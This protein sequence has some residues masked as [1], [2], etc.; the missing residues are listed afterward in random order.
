MNK[1]III[2]INGIVFHIEEEAYDVLRSYMID[3]KKYFGHTPDSIEIVGDIEN[4]I[5]EMFSERIQAGKK[6]VITMQDVNEVINQMGSVNEFGSEATQEESYT[7]NYQEPEPSVRRKLMRD[8]ED[9]VFGG[10][11]S[12]IGHYFGIEARWV[13]LIFILLFLTAGTGFLFYIILWAVVPVAKNRADRMAMRGEAPNLK[14]FQRSFQEEMEGIR[15]NFSEAGGSGRSMLRSAGTIITN[16]IVFM[17]KA[18]GILI[19]LAICFG[20]VTLLISVMATFGA[21][22]GLEH[23]MSMFPMNIVDPETRT[24]LLI[25]ALA[26]VAIPLFAFIGLIIRILFNRVF[27]G[28]YT[29]FTLLTIWLF[30]IGVCIHYGINIGADFREE[31]TIVEEKPLEAYP[32]YTLRMND[33]SIIKLSDSTYIDDRLG[34]V[35]KT[36]INRNSSLIEKFRRVSI[37]VDRVDSLQQPMVIYEF[38]AHGKTYDLA[39]ERAARLSYQMVQKEN[40]LVFDSHF[41]LQNDELMREQD[42]D[43]RILLPVGTQ[44][45]IHPDAHRYLSN[46][47]LNQCRKNYKAE[48]GYEPSSISF[49]MTYNGLKC[50]VEEIPEN[51]EDAMGT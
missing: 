33:L 35:K 48:I 22:A 17:A 29:G 26:V 42:V 6:E 9:R 10:V 47:P 43:V 14:N 44:L 41:F 2:N 28:R 40:E 27:I 36:A 19:I 1:T 21:I 38:Q 8:P 31:S 11:A 32:A 5:A 49:I 24:T 12:G 23:E 16:I 39:S 4:R 18:I 25:A 30:A 50:L 13:R 20:L 46:I 51:V 3:V 34:T 45:T 37:R 7:H 15:S